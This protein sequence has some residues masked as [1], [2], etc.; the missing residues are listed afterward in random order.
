MSSVVATR[1]EILARPLQHNKHWA[2]VTPIKQDDGE[3]QGALPVV[4]IKSVADQLCTHTARGSV[5]SVFDGSHCVPCGVCL[6]VFE[7]ILHTIQM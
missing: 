5:L 1:E 2:D 4:P 7:A 3:E 6:C